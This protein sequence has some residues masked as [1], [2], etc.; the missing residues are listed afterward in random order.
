[1]TP[2]TAA[3][4]RKLI[5]EAVALLEQLPAAIERQQAAR[6]QAARAK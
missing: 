2:E 4:V 1:M 3:E 6:E 5:E